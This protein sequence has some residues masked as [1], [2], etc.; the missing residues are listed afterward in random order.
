MADLANID[1][2]GAAKQ[3]IEVL[4]PLKSDAKTANALK[5]VPAIHRHVADVVLSHDQRRIPVRLE[6]RLTTRTVVVEL[7]LVT[8]DNRD[9]G[10]FLDFVDEPEQC[11]LCELVIMIKHPD[12]V[13]G[14]KSQGLIRV[15]RD[16]S[17]GVAIGHLD[18]RIRL[19]EL[20]KDWTH[21]GVG[22]G[23]VRNA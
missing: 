20:L 17:V 6:Q 16:V 2:L 9:I 1:Q 3:K 21:S 8:I 12:V 10:I 19:R 23:V 11:L 13:A 7:V 5:Q 18:T 15:H 22:R 4:T 14:R